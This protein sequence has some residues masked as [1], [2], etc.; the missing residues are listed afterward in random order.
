[1]DAEEDYLGS[2]DVNNLGNSK[3]D[4][5]A[6]LPQS[7]SLIMDKASDLGDMTFCM[8]NYAKESMKMMFMMRSH[9]M[10]TDVILEV[11][12]ELFH[13]HKVVLAAASP[14]FKVRYTPLPLLT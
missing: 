12:T 4:C 8:A 1:M 9:H 7:C 11:G 14:Y 13:A 10:L 2:P 3:G 6:P 5:F